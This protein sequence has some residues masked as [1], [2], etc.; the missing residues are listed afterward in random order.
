MSVLTHYPEPY[1]HMIVN[2]AVLRGNQQ[3]LKSK[4]QAYAINFDPPPKKK[5]SLAAIAHFAF[6]F[7][8]V[9][10]DQV[11]TEPEQIRASY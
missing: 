1:C 10:L 2:Y 11:A 4:V 9:H 3:I 5:V 6:Q 7:N 8:F